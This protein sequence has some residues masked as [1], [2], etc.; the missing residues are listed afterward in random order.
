M[1]QYLS[2]LFC[3]SL[4]FS[5]ILA[6]IGKIKDS[7]NPDVVRMAKTLWSLGLSE[8][9]RVKHVHMNTY[10]AGFPLVGWVV[11]LFGLTFNKYIF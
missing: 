2:T 1:S 6:H 3:I 4:C 11:L 5:E 7:F 9:S 10:I 8:C